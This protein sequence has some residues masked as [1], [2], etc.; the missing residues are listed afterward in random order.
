[1]ECNLIEQETNEMKKIKKTIRLCISLGFIVLIYE[2]GAS[3]NTVPVETVFWNLQTPSYYAGDEFGIPRTNPSHTDT[4]NG[5]QLNGS[6][7]RAGVEAHSIIEADFSTGGDIYFSWKAN[8]GEGVFLGSPCSNCYMRVDFG[9]G[10]FFGTKLINLAGTAD[11]TG[12]TVSHS[13]EGSLLISPDTWYFSH[14]AIADDQ[15]YTTVTSVNNYDDLGGVPVLTSKGDITDKN[16][17]H[18]SNVQFYANIIDSYGAANASVVVSEVKY[19][20]GNVGNKV[21]IAE[22]LD[23]HVPLIEYQTTQQSTLYSANFEY[24]GKNLNNELLW[25]LKNYEEIEDQL[26]KTVPTDLYGFSNK[27]MRIYTSQLGKHKFWVDFEFIGNIGEEGALVWKL[28][29]FGFNLIPDESE[30]WDLLLDVAR[31][32]DVMLFNHNASCPDS[33]CSVEGQVPTVFGNSSYGFYSH[34]ALISNIDQDSK[35]IEI[36]HARGSQFASSEQVRKDW[37]D[38]NKLRKFYE[39]GKIGVYR[40][41]SASDSKAE[42]TVE[43]AIIKY[44]DF[45]YVDSQDLIDGANNIY[46]SALIRNAYNDTGIPLDDGDG[47]TSVN[48]FSAFLFTPDE[49]A[50]SKLLENIFEWEPIDNR[51]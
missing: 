6:G 13:F 50:S 29:D 24:S 8:G 47:L 9:I 10:W 7:Y 45:I 11:I 44:N 43:N 15:Q 20:S 23:F 46:N 34:A 18:I 48:D 2:K 33:D 19:F 4:I 26:E 51:Q 39:R 5:L 16:W 41:N 3:A 21:V 1:M 25:K 36:F 49:L 22:N 27:F 35:K 42:K 31:I 14:I 12:L 28:Q 17:K 32:G 38:M 30:D 37:F 40:V